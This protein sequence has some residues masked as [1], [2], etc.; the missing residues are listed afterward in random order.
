MG[1]GVSGTML[2][3]VRVNV[4]K[5]GGGGCVVELKI[6]VAVRKSDV[7]ALEGGT[8]WL[9]GREVWCGHVGGR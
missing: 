9:C 5:D 8:V 2:S 3:V 7:V 6:S 4:L 1:E